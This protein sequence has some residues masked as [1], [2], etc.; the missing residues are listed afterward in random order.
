M[1][2]SCRYFVVLTVVCHFLTAR[3]VFFPAVIV[4]LIYSSVCLFFPKNRCNGPPKEER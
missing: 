4:L 1:L 3:V 2:A